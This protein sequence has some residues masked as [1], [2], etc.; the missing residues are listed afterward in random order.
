MHNFRHYSLD[1]LRRGATEGVCVCVCV[2]GGGGHG[3]LPSRAYDFRFSQRSVMHV[4]AVPLRHNVNFGAIIFSG[5]KK[6]VGA[7]PPDIRI[8]TGGALFLAWLV[9]RRNFTEAFCHP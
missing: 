5:R 6:C 8:R 4:D 1:R 7:T 3:H 9:W 2:C